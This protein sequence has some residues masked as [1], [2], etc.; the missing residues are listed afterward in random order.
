MI[1]IYP[2]ESSEG[3]RWMERFAMSQPDSRV[4]ERLLDALDRPRPFRRFKDALQD[5]PQVREAW[6]RHE[7][8][9]LKDA[10]REWLAY[11]HVA[12]ELVEAPPPEPSPPPDARPHRTER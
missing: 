1:R 4:R 3:F 2:V 12:A 5:F 10:A 7:D 11:H 9:K 6:H 8:G